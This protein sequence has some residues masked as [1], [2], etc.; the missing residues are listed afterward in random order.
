MRIG[1]NID[2]ILRNILNKAISTHKKY[3]KSE[4]DIKEIT[5]Y[6]LEK[7]FTFENDESLEKFLYEDCS[8]EIYGGADEIEDHIITKLNSFITENLETHEVILLTRECGRAIP[9]TLFFLS[10]SSCM[11]KNIK[12]VR[13]Y[14]EMWEECDLLLTTFPHFNKNKPKDKILVKVE[15]NYNKGME[16]D[17]ELKSSKEF[18]E[19][20]YLDQ[21]INTKKVD[22]KELN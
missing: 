2:G 7:Y 22:Y 6:D 21:I 1:I 12:F 15:R 20:G 13:S 16:S 5:D 18:F 14:D 11:C 4:I 19:E 3:Y 8:L 9:S 10:K 17:Y